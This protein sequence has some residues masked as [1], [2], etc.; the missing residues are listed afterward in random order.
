VLGRVLVG[1][2]RELARLEAALA[3]SRGAGASIFA[4]VG[5]PGIGKTRLLAE[6]GG[7]A[8]RRGLAVF[9]GAATELEHEIPFGPFVDA[10]DPYLASVSRSR[11]RAL[12]GE[13]RAEPRVNGFGYVQWCVIA[14]RGRSVQLGAPGGGSSAVRR[15]PPWHACQRHR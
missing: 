15:W 3:G 11:L 14:P 6:F 9:S 4:I 5:E 10:L 13:Q 1:R 2:K 7:R 8:A 12:T